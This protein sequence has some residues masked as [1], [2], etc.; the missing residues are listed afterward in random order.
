MSVTS[1][2]LDWEGSVG[3]A[4]TTKRSY[5]S[6]YRV[7]TDDA[8][9]QARVIFNHLKYTPSLPWFGYAYGYANDIDLGAFVVEIDPRRDKG[10]SFLWRV[11]VR[12][13]TPGEEEE[14][15]DDEGK[16]TTDPLEW[17]NEIEVSKIFITVPV[18]EAQYWGARKG[19]EDF[20]V[21]PPGMIV[22]DFYPPW[23]SARQLYNPP[24]ETSQAIQAFRIT[25]TMLTYPADTALDLVNAVNDND[26][27]LHLP[28]GPDRE[29]ETDFLMARWTGLVVDIGGS[30]NFR[31]GIFFWRNRLEV[32]WKDDTWLDDIPDR[33]FFARVEVGDPKG[34]VGAPGEVWSD[35]EI[36]ELKAAGV[37]VARVLADPHGRS[38]T[39]P[40]LLDGRGKPLPPDEDPVYHRWLKYKERDFGTLFAPGGPFSNPP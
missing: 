20:F 18:Y 14:K 13:E 35:N 12:F 24:L 36:E 26:F 28:E 15:Q 17:A 1:V 39:E 19:G 9:D 33:G 8:N 7:V 4:T 34:I 25:E 29:G 22:G 38:F 32:H 5:V 37:P 2:T 31:N 3:T 6:I 10:S 21:D 23:N 27:T 40:I 30:L 11:V 16:P